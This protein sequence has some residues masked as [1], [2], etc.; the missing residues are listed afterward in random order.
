MCVC[1]CVCVRSRACVLQG[2]L[3]LQHSTRLHTVLHSS[4]EGCRKC[5]AMHPVPMRLQL[6]LPSPQYPPALRQSSP[7]S[8]IRLKPTYCPDP[9][10]GNYTFW[11]R[12]R[13]AAHLSAVHL[14]LHGPCGQ[15]AVHVDVPPLSQA[16]RAVLGLG[17]EWCRGGGVMDE[18]DSAC[19]S[20]SKQPGCNIQQRTRNTCVQQN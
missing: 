11:R 20:T 15:Q 9:P 14:L 4:P 18:S 17:Q 7:C 6:H 1:V 3:V 19:G 5:C 8:T 16:V 13:P 12:H 10:H 2:G